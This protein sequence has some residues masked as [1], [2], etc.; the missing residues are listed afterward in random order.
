MDN[1]Q[2]F[3]DIEKE[4]QEQQEAEEALGTDVIEEAPAEDFSV[5]VK[6]RAARFA[7]EFQ[8]FWAVATCHRVN[9]KTYFILSLLFG[10]AGIHRFYA[11]HY[12]S[13]ILYLSFFFIG[14]LFLFVHRVGMVIIVPLELMA[15]VQGLSVFL[16]KPDADGLVEA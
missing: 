14:F 12:L 4:M 11:R 5:T 2:D 16:R 7:E 13:G 10:A 1:Q 3:N 6:E 9:K 8:K 15:F